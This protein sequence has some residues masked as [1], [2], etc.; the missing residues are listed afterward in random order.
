MIWQVS[1]KNKTIDTLGIYH[2][3]P[4][5]DHT[6]TTFLDEITE[7]LITRLPNMENAIILGDF[8]MHIEDPNDYTSKIFVDTMEALGL[9]QYV[10]EPT[11][12]KG[13]ILDLIFTETSFQIN[14][15]QLKMLDF[16]SDHRLVSAT[17]NVK[18]DDVL[19]ITRKK[20]RNF[21]EVSPAMM[22]ENF[23]PPHFRL[24]TNTSEA[25]TQFILQLQ[26]MLDKCM[27]EKIIKRPRK[28]QNIWFN[29]TLQQQQKIV[30]NRGRIWRKYRKQHHWKAYTVERN[31][32]ICQLHYFKQQSISKRVLGCKKNAKELFL[33]VNKLT[34]NT[35]QNPLPPYKTDKELTEDLT[36]FFICKIERIRESFINTPAYKAIYQDI[37][38][39]PSFCPLTESKVHAVI[40]KMRNKYCELDIIPTTIVKQILDACLLMITQIVNLSLTNGEFCEDWK[41]TVVKPLLKKPGIDL[42]SK[43][44]RPISNLPFISKLV[45]KWMLKQL[46]RHCNNHTLLQDFQSAY[47][48]HYSME[49][50]LI[51]LTMTYCG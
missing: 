7:L 1:L 39:F 47:Q 5:Q 16:I 23:H 49:T 10:V 15:S 2:P 51:R 14:I 45:E 32:Y 17:I 36:R 37:P 8:N 41:T 43:N 44:Y 6:N 24:N 13:N 28:P 21:K 34:G 31:K 29:N 22:M 33:L 4:K 46:L 9:R 25:H 48:K 40:M 38:Q 3:P 42:I 30:K 18:K 35:M 26:K 19:K 20:I 12:Q 11:H 27:P 50:S